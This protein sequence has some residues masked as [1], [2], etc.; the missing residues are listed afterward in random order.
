[1][2]IDHAAQSRD[3]FV[4]GR[5]AEQ[6]R[7]IIMQQQTLAFAPTQLAN[8][9]DNAHVAPSST[10][11]IPVF[12]P[13][14]SLQISTVPYSSPAD[15]DFA[16]ASSA[17]AFPI[18]SALTIKSR[19]SMLQRCLGLFHAHASELADVF[20]CLFMDRL[21]RL[22][23]ERLGEK[24]WRKSLRDWKRWNTR[25]HCRNSRK[26]RSWRCLGILFFPL[27]KRCLLS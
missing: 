14:T 11:S 21:S 23:M 20:S 10:H 22:N 24:R 6:F 12:N 9:I 15:V 3:L 26:E 4:K 1:M 5:A 27:L 19:C 13:S 25:F 16:L 2:T 17:R 7:S 8:Y 18:W